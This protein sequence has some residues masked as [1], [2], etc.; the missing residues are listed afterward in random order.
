M[1]KVNLVP[2]DILAKA[3]QRQLMLQVSA[4]GALLLVLMTGISAGHLYGKY[5]L[6]QELA[7]NEAELKRLSK[8][9][10]QVEDLERAAAAVRARLN[11]IEDLLRS[12]AFFPI[13]MSEFARSVPPGVRVTNLRTV[14]QPGSALKLDIS[15]TAN[16]QEDIAAWVR[17]LEGN[18]RFATVELGAVTSAGGTGRQYTFTISTTYTQKL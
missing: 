10:A 8:I 12:R 15:A 5:R 3:A 17:G 1:I 6:D 4:V 14:S 7:Y 2:A 18:G 9:V 11:V 16:S 13:F